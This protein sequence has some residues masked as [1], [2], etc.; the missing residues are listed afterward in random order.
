M[1]K[2]IIASDIHGNLENLK[3]I[4]NIAEK[5]QVEKIIFLGD[6]FSYSHE[7]DLEIIKILNSIKDKV[8]ALKGNGDSKY[9]EEKLRFKLHNYYLL[10][11]EGLTLFLT[12]GHIDYKKFLAENW[13]LLTGHTHTYHLSKR[14]INPGSLSYPRQKKE[15]TYIL[16]ENHEFILYNIEKEEELEKFKIEG[17]EEN[18]LSRL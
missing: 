1:K 13:I 12:H 18:D 2:I 10:E 7:N 6:Y 16:Y 11:L 3:K 17:V 9:L 14:W 5:K 15:K 8:I 4:I